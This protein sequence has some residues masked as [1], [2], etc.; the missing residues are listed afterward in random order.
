MY[1]SWTTLI[2]SEFIVF[3][4]RFDSVKNEYKFPPLKNSNSFDGVYYDAQRITKTRFSFKHVHKSMIIR[5]TNTLLHK[6]DIESTQLLILLVMSVQN[7]LIAGHF[8][9]GNRRNLF[10]EERSTAWLYDCFIFIQFFKAGVLIAHQ[11]TIK[12]LLRVLVL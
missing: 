5:G 6:C 3:T 9:T 12:A 11:Y 1:W 2:L 7:P 10:Y 8:L 4:I